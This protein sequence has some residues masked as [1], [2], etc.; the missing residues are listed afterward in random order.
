[1]IQ[2]AFAGAGIDLP[3]TAAEQWE[4]TPTIEETDLL[5]GDLVFFAGTTDAPGVTH[6]AM[7]VGAG[8]MV[9]APDIDDIV[10]L[11]SI[12]DPWWREHMVGF[13]RVQR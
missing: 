3:R 1:L 5:P 8:L 6:V 11:V 13:T 10:R 12:N 7:Y 9:N 2:W 4:W